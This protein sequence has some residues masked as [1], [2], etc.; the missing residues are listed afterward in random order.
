MRSP[1][2]CLPTKVRPLPRWR[3]AA[4]GAVWGLL[5][6]ARPVVA[7]APCTS[8]ETCL[9]AIEAAQRATRSITADFVQVKH[10]SLL[11]EPLTSTGHFSFTRPDH[12]ELQIQQPQPATIIINGQ[13][14]QIPNLPERDRQAVA[15]APIAA[16]FTQLGA[17]FTGSTQTL[18]AGFEVTAQSADQGDGSIHVHLVPRVDSWKRMF[19]AIDIRFGGT[20]LVAQEIRIEDGFGDRLEITLQNIRRNGL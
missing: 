1:T 19:R 17:I 15:M 9:H 5:L 3:N 12:V 4:V 13:D 14:V 16:M 20:E 2:S 11:D 8:T 6:I 7:A 10:L 18:Q